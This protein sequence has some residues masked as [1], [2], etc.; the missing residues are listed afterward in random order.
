MRFS[1]WLHVI[2]HQ[3]VKRNNQPKILPEIQT[4]SLDFGTDLTIP[5]P[6]CCIFTFLYYQLQCSSDVLKYDSKVRP[7][8]EQPD[9]M[10][11]VVAIL[12]KAW[13]QRIFHPNL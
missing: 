10:Q 8:F 1:A 5:P 12:Y 7:E 2:Q 3:F 9:Q 13:T 4:E 6:P 11:A